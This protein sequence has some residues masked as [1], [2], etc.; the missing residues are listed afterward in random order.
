[1]ITFGKQIQTK[2]DLFAAFVQYLKISRKHLA[3]I[4]FKTTD[5]QIKKLSKSE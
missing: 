4:L 5:V 2:E 1:M 3:G